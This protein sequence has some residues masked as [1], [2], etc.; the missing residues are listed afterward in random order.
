M[1]TT[2][3]SLLGLL[4][5]GTAAIAQERPNS[6]QYHAVHNPN[7]P[8]YVGPNQQPAAPQPTGYWEK[9][10]GAIAGNPTTGILGT[11]LGANS[12]ADATRQAIG[13]CQSKGGGGR[14]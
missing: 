8:Y 2:W 7:S 11:A 13:D 9:T 4:V 6:A 5:A 14:L 3:L 1:K 12:K 10:W